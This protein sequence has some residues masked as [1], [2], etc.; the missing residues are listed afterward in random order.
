MSKFEDGQ[1]LQIIGHN[2]IILLALTVNKLE[3]VCKYKQYY[4]LFNKKCI[5]KICAQGGSRD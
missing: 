5:E 3:Q 1:P 4:Y 2:N